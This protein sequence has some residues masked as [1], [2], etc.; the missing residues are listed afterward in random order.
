MPPNDSFN[1]YYP[2]NEK[3]EH[4]P[5][6]LLQPPP[7]Y[8]NTNNVYPQPQQQQNDYQNDYQNYQSYPPNYPA[9]VVNVYDSN[10]S[11]SKR[12]YCGVSFAWIL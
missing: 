6:L 8:N 5:L 4:Q 9:T 12:N 7:L 1:N 2:K 3:V 10:T 11:Y